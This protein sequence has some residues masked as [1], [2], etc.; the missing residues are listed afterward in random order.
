MEQR[1]FIP[2]IKANFENFEYPKEKLELVIVDDGIDNLMDQ[3][4]DD[5]RLLYLH[6]SDKEIIEFIEKIKFDNDKDDMLKNYQTKTK[7]LP[8][9]FKI[10]Y[11]VGMSSTRVYVPYGL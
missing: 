5:E 4:L 2:L 3:F 11:G 7:S 9:G 8:N 1:E 6:I 10:H